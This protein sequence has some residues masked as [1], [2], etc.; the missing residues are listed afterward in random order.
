MKYRNAL[1]AL[2]LLASITTLATF[3]QQDDGVRGSQASVH[4]GRTVSGSVLI[5]GPGSLEEIGGGLVTGQPYSAERVMEHTQTLLNG[6]HIDQKREMSRVYRDSE[7]RVRT[8][9]YMFAGPAARNGTTEAGLQLVHIYDPV[10]GYSYT[11]DTEKHIAHRIAVPIPSEHPRPVRSEGMLVQKPSSRAPGKSAATT[12]SAQ[13]RQFKREALGTQVIEGLTAEGT[14]LTM[15]TAAGVEGNDRPL[16][17]VCDHW[18]S[19]ELKITILSNCTD[20]RSGNSV[21]RMQN[22]D[23]AEPDPLLFQ[24]PP[25]YTVEEETGPYVVGYRAVQANPR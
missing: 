17:R 5:G 9:R 12:G 13:R 15:T 21:I 8:E 18:Q 24:V 14:R 19:E 1:S 23:R 11:L 4:N 10:A 20:P 16:T 22:I 7:G 6:T 2:F 25:D 3:A